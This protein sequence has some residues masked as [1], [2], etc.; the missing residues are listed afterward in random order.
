MFMFRVG[1]TVV[2]GVSKGRIDLFTL[3]GSRTFPLYD[4]SSEPERGR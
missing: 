1:R 2:L 4:V 3:G